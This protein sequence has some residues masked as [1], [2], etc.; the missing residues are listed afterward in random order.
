LALDGAGGGDYVRGI[1]STFPGDL[2]M[3]KKP[4]P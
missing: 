1:I 3:L 4:K 2:L